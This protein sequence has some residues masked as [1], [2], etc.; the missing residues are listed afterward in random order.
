M[1]SLNVTP[2]GNGLPSKFGWK[3]EYGCGKANFKWD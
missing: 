1:I 2:L 3:K